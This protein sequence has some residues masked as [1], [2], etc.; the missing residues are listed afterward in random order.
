VQHYLTDFEQSQAW[1]KRTMNSARKNI[2]DKIFERKISQFNQF[3]PFKK[4][5]LKG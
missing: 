3:S 4:N 1:R 2:K 5:I